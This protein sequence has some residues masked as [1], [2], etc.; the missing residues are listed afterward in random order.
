MGANGQTRREFLLYGF[1]GTAGVVA[2]VLLDGQPAAAYNTTDI[3][4]PRF[5]PPTAVDSVRSVCGVCFWKCGIN[6]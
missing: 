6:V 5:Y 4:H 3:E 1:I 2:G